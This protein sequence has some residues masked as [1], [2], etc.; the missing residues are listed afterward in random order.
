MIPCRITDFSPRAGGE[1][2]EESVGGCGDIF[3]GWYEVKDCKYTVDEWITARRVST[4]AVQEKIEYSGSGFCRSD[5]IHG[6]P[7][8]DC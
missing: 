4:Q 6:F 2:L 1:E 8:S 7:I 3:G 5:K